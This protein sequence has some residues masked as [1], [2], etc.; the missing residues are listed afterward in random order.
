MTIKE[1]I[2]SLQLLLMNVSNEGEEEKRTYIED[3]KP[4]STIFVLS[5]AIDIL[6]DMVSCEPVKHGRLE[7]WGYVF[8]GIEWKRCSVCNKCAGVS[9]YGLLDGKIE[10]ETP[11]RCGC[12]G[13]RMDGGDENE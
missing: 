3:V 7:K 4:S 5:T 13:S 8:H 1:T 9:Y 11:A 10:M 12:C 2:E 6:Q